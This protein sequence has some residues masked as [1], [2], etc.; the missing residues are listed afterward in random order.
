[1]ELGDGNHVQQEMVTRWTEAHV[2]TY[3]QNQ[4]TIKTRR[5]LVEYETEF[6]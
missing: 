4:T 3:V 1:M 2:L 5:T 6:V